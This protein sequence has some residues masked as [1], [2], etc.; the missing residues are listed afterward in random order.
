MN[1]II[2]DNVLR[3]PEA[4]DVEFLYQYRNDWEVIKHL[5]GFSKG[6][7]LVDLQD[8]IEA[9]RA[10]DNELIWI[11]ADCQSDKCLGHVGLYN[12]DHRVRKAE[13]AIMI[14]DKAKCRT[15]IGTLVTRSVIE[16]GFKQLNLHRIYLTV[17]KANE[18]AIKLYE[19][20]GFKH[21]GMLRDEQFRDGEYADVVFMAIL[22]HEWQMSLDHMR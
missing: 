5:G 4:K 3:R 2:A 9:H 18:R 6:Y 22:E 15:G 8:W 1:L 17:L 12:I 21:E 13:F 20:L 14:G 11:I 7:S 19:K 10:K 16:Y